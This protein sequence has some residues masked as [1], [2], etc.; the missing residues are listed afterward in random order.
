[1]KSPIVS[2]EAC[3]GMDKFILHEGLF[4]CHQWTIYVDNSPSYISPKGIFSHVNVNN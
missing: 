3:R 2:A 4:I 1:M